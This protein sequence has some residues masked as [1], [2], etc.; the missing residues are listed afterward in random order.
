M[1]QE[2]QKHYAAQLE[3]YEKQLETVRGQ[4]AQLEAQMQ[5]LEQ[6]F[7]RLTA[8]ENQLIGALMALGQL[9]NDT[10]D[11]NLPTADVQ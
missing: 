8:V 7:I 1:T 2:L 3:K 5:Q 9:K 4:K 10:T 6:N 11:P